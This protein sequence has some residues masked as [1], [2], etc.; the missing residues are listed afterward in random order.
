[1]LIFRLNSNQLVRLSF[2]YYYYSRRGKNQFNNILKYST[3]FEY[4]LRN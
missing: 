1:M 4:L 3:L 2:E